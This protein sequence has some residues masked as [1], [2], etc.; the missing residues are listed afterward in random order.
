MLERVKAF[1]WGQKIEA[2]LK[3]LLV[4]LE[5]TLKNLQS[6]SSEPQGLVDFFN[7]MSGWTCV[8]KVEEI[9]EILLL[10]NSIDYGQHTETMKNLGRFCTQVWNIG[11][12]LNGFPPYSSSPKI[13]TLKDFGINGVTFAEHLEK[14]EK[15]DVSGYIS[16]FSQPV[17]EIIKKLVEE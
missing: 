10:L 8:E 17:I 9:E 11:L 7:T 6:L 16:S 14:G 1:F 4:E 12:G 15:I 13:V 2:Q 3:G 5:Q